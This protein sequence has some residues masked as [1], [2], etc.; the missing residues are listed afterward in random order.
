MNGFLRNFIRNQAIDPERMKA[1]VRKE[2]AERSLS[3][4]IRQAWSVIEPNTPYV[5]NWHIDL[6]AEYLQAVNDGEI[7]RLLINMPP[8][9]M[10]SIEATICY[11][12]WTWTRHPEKR[13]I[14]V[15]YSDSL[16]R[17]HN[18]RSRD[19]ILSN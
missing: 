10:K 18:A 1:V 4:F 3:V 5:H 15:S 2:R 8:R 12:V 9:H 13:F 6:I 14:K 11:P 19:I 7:H 16:S 17:E